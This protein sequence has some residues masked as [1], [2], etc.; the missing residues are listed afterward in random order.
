M[1]TCISSTYPS[2]LVG[3][4]VTLSNFHGVCVF[5]KVWPTPFRL[6]F[7]QSVLL[8]HLL[9]FA[10]LFAGVVPFLN[11]DDSIFLTFLPQPMTQQKKLTWFSRWA[12]CS[13]IIVEKGQRIRSCF[14]QHTANINRQIDKS[15]KTKTLWIKEPH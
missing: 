2:Q 10:S 11:V 15:V 13:I 9:N 6:K 12:L 7:F 4:L 14:F 3:P 8:T 5:G 1:V